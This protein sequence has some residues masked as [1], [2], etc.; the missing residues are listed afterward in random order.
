MN[1]KRKDAIQAA[2]SRGSQANGLA[3]AGGSRRHVDLGAVIVAELRKRRKRLR[4]LLQLLE[5]ELRRTGQ[6]PL[7]RDGYSKPA[8]RVTRRQH[9]A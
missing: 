7:P 6:L 1:S 8:G 2:L 9:A 3:A 5:G 4:R